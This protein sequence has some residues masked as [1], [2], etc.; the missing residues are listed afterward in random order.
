M[1][2]RLNHKALIILISLVLLFSVPLFIFPSKAEKPKLSQGVDL[3]IIML[4]DQQKPGVVNVTD[5]FLLDALGYGVDSVTVESSGADASV[6]LTNLQTILQGGTASAHVIAIDVVWTAPFADNGWIIDLDSYLDPNELDDYGSGIVDACEYQNSYF[7]YPYFMNLGV[8]YYRTDLMDIHYGVGM[9]DE[10]DFDT[11]EE[12]NETANYILNNETGLLDNPDLVGYIGQLDAYEGGVVNFFEWCGSNGALDVVTST[13]EVNIDTQAVNDAMTFIKALVPPQ[14][15]EVQGTDY[16]IPRYGLVHDEASS[17][18]LWLA[19][20]SIFCRQWPYIY[21]LSEAANIE[22]GLA[23]L[24]HFEGATGYKTSAVGGA[25]LAIP[26]ATTGV[27]REAAINL[28]KFLG[29]QLAQESELT[30]D[31][32]PGPGYIPQGNFPALTSVF[33]NPPAGFEW[34]KN[35]SD[36]ATLTL[37]RPVHPDYP[38]ISNTIADYFSDLLSCQKSVDDALEEMDRDVTEIIKGPPS[39]PIPGYSISI[40]IIAVACTVGIVIL[41]RKKFQ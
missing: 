2:E 3:T 18:N 40:L 16:I 22:F 9:W 36:Q 23:P 27:A 5:D 11:W 37:S 6:Q 39:E 7:A 29:D 30:A 14:Y 34:I 19:N 13:G 25:L 4:G 28:T 12:L 24:P 33:T 35:W 10:S 17:G 1:R 15:T 21:S 32:D 31:T 38:L 26:T 41:A 20:N 8:M